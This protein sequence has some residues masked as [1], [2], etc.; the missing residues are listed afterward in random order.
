[1]ADAPQAPVARLQIL[2]DGRVAVQI[3][4]PGLPPGEHLLYCAPG[5][6]PKNDPI[7]AAAALVQ[8]TS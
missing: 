8:R 7:I 4:A 2:E 1:M 3:L 5:T 6:A